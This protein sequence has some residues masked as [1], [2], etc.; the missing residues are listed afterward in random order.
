M[1]TVAEYLAMGYDRKASEYFAAG[2]KRI[3]SVAANDDHTLTIG[4][5]NGEK[6]L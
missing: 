3:V 5:D 4:F 1:K 6:R 2:H